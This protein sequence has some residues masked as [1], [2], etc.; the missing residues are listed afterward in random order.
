M[1]TKS[2]PSKQKTTEAI[3]TNLPL[4][5]QN[6]LFLITH[7]HTANREVIAEK[8]KII[9]EAN[10]TLKRTIELQLSVT[11]KWHLEILITPFIWKDNKF[12]KHYCP[13]NQRKSLH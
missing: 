12:Q 1:N 8:M 5:L 4:Y 11:L 3:F 7:K 9:V 10:H 13:C 6:K 2:R